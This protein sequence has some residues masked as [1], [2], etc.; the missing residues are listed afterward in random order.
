MGRQ[1][2][3]TVAF[4]VLS[5]LHGV[6]ASA[7]VEVEPSINPA[8][9][10][11]TVILSLSPSTSIKS[12]SWAVGE[13]QILTWLGEQQAVFPSHSGRASVN[14]LTGALTLSS[15]KVSDSGVYI[16]QGTDP[17]LKANTSITVLEAV[18]NVTLNATATSL[19]EFNSSAVITCSVS[20]GSSLSFLWINGSSVVTAGDRV[21]LT[22]GNSTLTITNV[23]RYDQGPFKC[24]VFNPVSN[25]TSDSVNFTITY[26]PDNMA[27]TVNG[28]NTTSFSVGSN[29]TMLCSVQSNPPAQLQWAFRGELVNT[30]GPLWEL[31]SVSKEQ[32]GPY[33]C[34][35]FNN[36]SNMNSTITTNILIST[37]SYS[38]MISASKNPLQVGS[39][40][41]LSSNASV[42]TGIWSFEGALIVFIFPGNFIISN[43]WTSRVE[44]DLNSSSLTIKSLTLEDSGKY[45]L[46]ALNI[47]DAEL[48]LDV[49][50]P[51]S[52]V[53]LKADNTSLVEFNDTAV[54]MCSVSNGSPLTYVWMKGTSVIKAGGGVQF[55][56]EDATL[57]ITRVTRDDEGLFKCNVSN[58]LNQEVSLPVLL[59]VSYG[60][61]NTK[62][63]IM[64]TGYNHRTGSNITLSCSAESSPSATIQW[65]LNGVYLNHLGPN[66]QLKMVKESD[67]GNYKCI[68]HNTVT[69]RFSSA[70]AMIKI[71]EPL[72]A[73]LLNNTGGPAIQ[74]G[75]LTLH[76]EVTG[77]VTLI[78]WYRNGQVLSADTSTMFDMGNKTLM[79]NPVKLSDKGEY[80]CEAFNEVS[81]VNSSSY[82]VEV[83]YG[84]KMP[85]ITGPKAA[86]PGDNV[87]LSCYA[88]SNPSSSY[89]WFF[90]STKVAN[91]SEYVTPPLTSDMVGMYTCMAFNGITGKNSTA[92]TMIKVVDSITDVKVQTPMHSAIEG[93]VYMLTCNVSGPAQHV[94]WM[95]NGQPL[96][97]DNRTTFSMDNKTVTLDPIQYHDTGKYQCVAFNPVRNMTSPPY[98][99]YVNFGPLT[100]VVK[101]PSYAEIGQEV[102][103]DCYAKSVPP[104]HYSWWYNG[105]E[106][107]NTSV[108]KTSPLTL[109]MSGE[110]TCMAYNNI[111][112]K[113]STSSQRLTVIVGPKTPV[114]KGPSYA[115]IGQEVNFDCYA[116]SVPPSH[117]SWWYNG[118]EVANTSVY[119]TSPLTLDMSGEYTCMAYNNITGKNSTSS[120]RLTVIVEPKT[121]VIKGPSYA[122][123]G[124]EVN[125]DCYA[126]SVPPS[127]Y[128][129]WY[130]GSEVANTSVYKTSPLTLDMSGE[131]TC[132]AY[133][134]ITGKNST[135]SQ[136]LTVIVGPK[137]PVIKG[138]SY[139][140][141]GQEVNFD[142]YAKS[143]P[144]SHYSWWYNGSEVANTSVYKTSPLTLDMSG[145]YTCMA[146][147]NITGKNSTSSQRLTVIVE[148]KT[149][150][151]KGPS[152]A[153]IGQEVNFDCYAK[154]VPPSHYSWWYNGSEVANTSV[155]KTS[156]LTLDMSGEYTCMAYNNIT[157]KNSTSSQRLTVIV[158]PKTPVIKGPSYAEIG[159][160][161][162]FDCYAKSVPPSHYSWWYNG[163]E[164]ANT[165]VYKT[166]PLTL[167]MSGEYTCM[168]YN[169]ITGKN[170]TSSQRLTVIVGPK[171]P[172]IKGPSYAEI[173]QEVNFDCYAKSVPPSHYSW[174]YNGSEVA[175]TSV[176]K[177]SPLTLDMSGEYTCMAY[178]NITGKNSTSSQRLTVIEA[179]ES[180][181]ITKNTVP[182]ISKNFT[183]T[184]E[185]S[186]PY[187]S[188]YWMKDNMHLTMN[189]STAKAKSYYPEDNMLHF[190]P[191][192]RNHDG[193]YMCV[194]TNKA[195]SHLSDPYT[196]LVNYG[197]LTV[198]ILGVNSIQIGLTAIMKCFADSRPD[199]EFN[200]FYNDLSSP[201]MAGSVLSFPVTNDSDGTYICKA[202][203]PVTNITMYG[204]KEFTAHAVGLH[205][206]SKA[207][208]MMGLLAL[209][210]NVLFN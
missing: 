74:D 181:K 153:E 68:S 111:T 69:S 95:K 84:P 48:R 90:N 99:L 160:E 86:I 71:V 98:M 159:Q 196:L 172:V 50:V 49:Q 186:G 187:D 128:S 38:Q 110:Y 127:H 147:N 9:V 152:Y 166:S 167:D 91:T 2:E 112:G 3:G 103:F 73:V 17:Q 179:I 33:S 77:S 66:L 72:G 18:S 58:L 194:A 88:S 164:V 161:V 39:T 120:Q 8:V 158:G 171:T 140:E 37:P 177:T 59:N 7:A 209:S 150:V 207:A 129:W 121:P 175:N 134:N 1:S 170:S 100:P 55:S 16:V 75:T 92:H 80:Q 116:K 190:T 173:G 131:Y 14:V 191:V 202:R 34:V 210:V 4:I 117:Y 63:M 82:T 51:V 184:C 28:Q 205:T 24:H 27:L 65:M 198:K 180:V 22:D 102:N 149:P 163:S 178:N 31:F 206:Q 109:D 78:Q 43:T 57:T 83:N 53:S 182:I 26:G 107:A 108:Y 119:K 162:N 185:V 44:F 135:S 176:Y 139:A 13:S 114:I 122:E 19:T 56:D 193:M 104:S 137:T 81:M 195:K 124:Q 79:L 201:L 52:G 36:H 183:L 141:I 25:E 174:W 15:V 126:K 67:S 60:P 85:T 151:I 125:F 12:G 136:R 146:Y 40:V 188:I 200:W 105:S 70:S 156:P 61:S 132:M 203:N 106:V 30:L 113:N 148:P 21:Q 35:A 157:G 11:D 93:H 115:E 97:D 29:L 41:I 118:S 144:P 46:Q 155:Y 101:G 6:L 96:H 45:T 94:Y 64:P 130:N 87:T 47:F 208:L 10:G 169:N 165:S 197:P 189:T 123:I 192:T 20:S 62:I 138:P 204:T 154:S 54:L 133:N 32:S 42:T 168:A 76:C 89:I 143:V 199:S 142:C 145:E 23:T 5:F